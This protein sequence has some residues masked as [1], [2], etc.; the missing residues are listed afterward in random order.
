MAGVS[1]CIQRELARRRA[2]S[3]PRGRTVQEDLLKEGF[4][5]LPGVHADALDH[6]SLGADHDVLLGLARDVNLGADACD[7]GGV[8][9]G[10]HHDFRAVGDLLLVVRQVSPGRFPTRRSAWACRST[11]PWEEGLA[12]WRLLHDALKQGVHVEVVK[13]ADGDHQ[14][15]E[16]R[17]RRRARLRRRF[18]LWRGQSC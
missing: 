17:P 14:A 11:R 5:V 10:L 1:P 2:S 6:A 3:C 13:G 9:V 4:D 8:F 18:G 15:R 16:L 12:F 7:V